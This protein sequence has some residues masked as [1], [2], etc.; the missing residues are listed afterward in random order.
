[1]V[2]WRMEG[3][4]GLQAVQDYCY[5]LAVLLFEDVVYQ[6]GFTGSEVA[7]CRISV[8]VLGKNGVLMD[9]LYL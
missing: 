4:G 7:C 8:Y 2:L 6:G 3:G 1:M 5:S 9:V